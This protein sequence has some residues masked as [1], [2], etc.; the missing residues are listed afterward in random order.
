VR[1][2][3]A[4]SHRVRFVVPDEL[5]AT[6]CP[7]ARPQEGQRSACGNGR[8][9]ASVIACAACER[10]CVRAC[11]ASLI[12]CVLLISNLY[13]S[14][15]LAATSR[16]A[17]MSANIDNADQRLT[18]EAV[19]ARQLCI[20]VQLISRANRVREPDFVGRKPSPLGTRSC[21]LRDRGL[22]LDGVV[23]T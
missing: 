22:G 10:A 8:S 18:L 17:R 11:A 6:C 13:A 9:L 12:A 23:R 14:A 1:S 3:T 7:S 16:I 2:A 20:T 4:R 19:Q 21:H 5:S 15:C